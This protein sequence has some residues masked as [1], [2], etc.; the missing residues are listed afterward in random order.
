MEKAAL[1]AAFLLAAGE[2]T[3]L[4]CFALLLKRKNSFTSTFVT[5]IM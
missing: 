3:N 4:Y 2:G 1:K 5:L